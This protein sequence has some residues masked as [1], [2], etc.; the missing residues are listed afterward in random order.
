MNATQR[1]ALRKDRHDLQR[2]ALTNLVGAGLKLADPVLLVAVAAQYGAQRFG[3]FYVAQAVVLLLLRVSLVGMDKALLWWV[4]REQDR[5]PTPLV[6]R[7]ARLALAVPLVV[8]LALAVGGPSLAVEWPAAAA[9]TPRLL[10]LSLPLLVVTELLTHATMGLRRMG[11]NVM[12]KDALIPIAFPG[13]ALVLAALGRLDDG[14]GIAYLSANAIG[15]AAAWVGYRR[16]FRGRAEGTAATRGLMAFAVPMWAAEV[17]NS[18]LQRVDVLL[19]EALTGDFGLAGVWAVVLK[20]ANAL[21]A[22]RRSF[23]P[24]VASIAAEPAVSGSRLREVLG[25][26]TFLVLATQIP[27]AAVLWV[28]ADPLLASFGS[29]FASAGPPLL[30]LTAGWLVTSTLGLSGVALYACGHPRA[31]L[32]NTLIAL[33]VV[34]AAGLVTI[35]QWGL[36]GAALSVVLGSLS[37]SVIQAALLWQRTK[38]W[39]VSLAS[40]FPFAAAAVASAAAVLARAVLPAMPPRAT[41]GASLLVFGLAYAALLYPRAATGSV[42]ERT[43]ETGLAMGS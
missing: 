36:V 34:V 33:V 20:L 8:L 23:D 21:R 7:A 1:E 38:V 31:H 11:L 12:V 5:R 9:S 19:V 32:A 29:D 13:F 37:Q 35:P 28:F 25:R 40:V 6:R 17:S 30:V 15:A 4:P 39:G 18:L 2:G 27:V 26:A 41:D 10:V 14:L 16:V 43:E 3:L 42:G 22:I 24:V